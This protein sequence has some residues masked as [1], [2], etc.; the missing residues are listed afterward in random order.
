M[1][2]SRE[3]KILEFLIKHGDVPENR[4]LEDNKIN[5]RNFLYNL[6][7]INAFLENMGLKKIERREK[8]LYFDITQNLEKIYIVLNNIGKFDQ[9]ERIKILE[10]KLFFDE[11]LNLKKISEDLEVS[12]TTIKKDF[13]IL[14]NIL[15]EKNIKILYKNNFGYYIEYNNSEY[16][17]W[18]KTK[19][20]EELLF[21][22][23]K[24]R[25]IY[26][27]YIKKIFLKN[28][29]YINTNK[30]S[31]FL[32]D[33]NENLKLNMK[34]DVYQILYSYL[35]V[36]INENDRKEKVS[37]LFIEKTME[38]KIIRESLKKNNIE[39]LDRVSIIKFVDF[40]MGITINKL[41]LETWL[42]EEILIR[43]M[44]KEFFRYADLNVINDEVLFECLIYHLKPTIYRIKKGIHISNTIFNELIKNNDP[45][46]EIT[47][48]VV[49]VIE[50]EINISF[51]EDE[52]ALLGYHFKASAER[53]SDCIKK[54][55]ILVC[56]LGVGTSKLLEHNLKE[57]FNM[58]IV[59]V[60]PY[61]KLDEIINSELEIDLILTTLELKNIYNI[62]VLKINPLLDEK[63]INKIS[64]YGVSKRKRKILLSELLKVIEE[65]PDREKL[66]KKLEIKFR[67]DVLDD[68]NNKKEKM[69]EYINYSDIVMCNESLDWKQAIKMI[70][71][72]MKKQGYI[73][74]KYIQEMIDNIKKF[75]SYI[76][77]EE[78]IA[79]PHGNI[80]KNVMKDGIS[81]LISKKK[82]FLPDKKFVN[83]FIAF[84]IKERENQ[85]KVLKF[86]FELATRENLKENLIKLTNIKNVISYLKEE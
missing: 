29:G 56:G 22:N 69:E 36:I 34:D 46:L 23:K 55:I 7:N 11:K 84:A 21:Q 51:P 58:E 83:I 41:N 39:N 26:L 30:V 40:L 50:S 43:K 32:N 37:L 82:I 4:I 65:N 13:H 85:Q 67:D 5:K 57:K 2:N 12:K 62:P 75:G 6:Q 64:Q 15:S 78:G 77:I 86:I 48:K 28:F 52:V 53:N 20:I 1:L 33:I 24:E 38:F 73:T 3:I 35:L 49:S 72:N 74:D 27:E 68:I 54:K 25:N 31:A 71:K 18:L 80:S 79:I 19:K 63:D 14:K 10:Y 70:G 59:A 47:R 8:L 42:N 45:I 61:Y 76:V 16:K 17:E 66:I 9:K 60:I 81:L 44:M